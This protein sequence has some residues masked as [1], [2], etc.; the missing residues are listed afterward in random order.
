[1]QHSQLQLYHKYKGVANNFLW[2]K[3][4]FRALYQN[5]TPVVLVANRRN[6]IC[7]L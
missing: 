6:Q 5:R 1:M 2:R 4:R 7:S 3:C